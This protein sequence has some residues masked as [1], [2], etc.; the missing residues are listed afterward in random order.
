MNI[1]MNVMMNK[2]ERS[3]CLILILLEQC[4][5]LNMR[6][7]THK[8]GHTGSQNAQ[9]GGDAA[10]ERRVKQRGFLFK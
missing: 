5:R 4:S 1:M 7:C 8:E 2:I 9:L 6:I 3:E 10:G